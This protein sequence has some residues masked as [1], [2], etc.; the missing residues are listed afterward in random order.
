MKSSKSREVENP[1]ATRHP[2]RDTLWTS[3]RTGYPHSSRRRCHGAGIARAPEPVR[4]PTESTNYRSPVSYLEG[5]YRR[6]WER[7]R[8]E[9]REPRDDGPFR[10]FQTCTA[11]LTGGGTTLIL[12]ARLNSCGSPWRAPPLD[13]LSPSLRAH[14]G[15]FG[16]AAATKCVSPAT[17]APFQTSKKK[18]PHVAPRHAPPRPAH[19]QK[20]AGAMVGY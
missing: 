10:P 6:L 5:A 12:C 1:T 8:H 2:F 14:I 7:R 16:S 4:H 9:M 19:T 20:Q 17:L 15:N 3:L 13:I 18:R 11:N